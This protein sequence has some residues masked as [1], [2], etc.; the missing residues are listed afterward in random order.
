MKNKDAILNS[1]KERLEFK[2][3][4]FLEVLLDIRDA[5]KEIHEEIT[6][7]KWETMN[8]RGRM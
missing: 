7:I 8:I 4:L 2:D 5:L 3:A 1:C 6:E